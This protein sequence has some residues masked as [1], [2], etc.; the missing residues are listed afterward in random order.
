[1]TAEVGAFIIAGED[2]VQKLIGSVVSSN[3]IVRVVKDMLRPPL[4]ESREFG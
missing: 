1:M 4:V 2:A 3:L